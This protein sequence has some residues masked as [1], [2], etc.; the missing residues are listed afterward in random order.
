MMVA[1]STIAAPHKKDAYQ[2]NHHTEKQGKLPIDAQISHRERRSY[3]AV[4]HTQQHP[5]HER[6]QT[7]TINERQKEIHN[8]RRYGKR[9]SYDWNEEIADLWR[10]IGR[11]RRIFW[12]DAYQGE[13][14]V[15]NHEDGNTDPNRNN[16]H[17]VPSYGSRSTGGVHAV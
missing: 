17:R 7:A 8:N 9:A 11:R 14:H 5:V 6:A 1:S 2:R 10:H 15:R 16:H 4:S 12:I 3:K 13:L